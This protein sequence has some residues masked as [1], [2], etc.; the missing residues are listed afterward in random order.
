MSPRAP[1]GAHFVF[2]HRRH[3]HQSFLMSMT[4]DRDT[5]D[6]CRPGFRA[7]PALSA[8]L[9]ALGVAGTASGQ[10]LPLVNPSFETPRIPTGFPASTMVDGWQ[11]AP[12]PPAGFGISAEQWDQMAGTFPNPPAGQPRHLTNADGTQVAFLFAVPG[13]SLSQQTPYPFIAGN[14]YNLQVGLR[15]GG[16]LTPG[17]Q[18]QLSLYYDNGPLNRVRVASTSVSAT[19]AL[20]SSSTLETFSVSLDPATSAQPWIGRNLGVEVMALSPN[21]AQG[22]AYWE[23]DKVQL[24]SVPEPGT[25]AL[26]AAGAAVAGLAWV[27]RRRLS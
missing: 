19:D 14:S 4:Q 15:G 23:L 18:F 26:L 27:R 10:S 9:I 6:T 12:P 25:G 8:L 1:G 21:G 5:H 17:T 7:T 2:S 16:A 20:T 22:I 13:V 3:V 11:K 24:T